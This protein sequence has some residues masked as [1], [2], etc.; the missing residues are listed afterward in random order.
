MTKQPKRVKS[1]PHKGLLK[2]IRIS[3]TGK[4]KHAKAGSKHLRSHKS[5][6]RLRRLRKDSFMST[7]EMKRLSKLLFMRLR[8]REQPRSALR[9]SPSPAERKAKRE[10]ARA[11]AAAAAPAK[12]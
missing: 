7:A 11:A 2:R 4:L 12:K 9:K 10:A 3:A 6:K 5:P 1:K 8:G